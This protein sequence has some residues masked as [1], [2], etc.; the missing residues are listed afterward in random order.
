MFVLHAHS[1]KVKQRRFLLLE[2]FTCL[3]KASNRTVAGS[4]FYVFYALAIGS[5]QGKQTEQRGRT[6]AVS[7]ARY[8]LPRAV[9]L[10]HPVHTCA[11]ASTSFDRHCRPASPCSTPA[12]GCKDRQLTES[13]T[14]SKNTRRRTTNWYYGTQIS[15]PWQPTCGAS[16]QE[17]LLLTRHR[18]RCHPRRGSKPPLTQV[19]VCRAA[20]PRVVTTARRSQGR[21]GTRDCNRGPAFHHQSRTS[22]RHRNRLR[23]DGPWPGGRC[24]RSGVGCHSSPCQ[25]RPNRL[26]ARRTTSAASQRHQPQWVREK[27][28]GHRASTRP[29]TSLGAVIATQPRQSTCPC[30]WRGEIPFQCL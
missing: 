14:L 13:V 16:S 24:R 25:H 29:A 22:A 11:T 18:R 26:Q 12:T 6:N 5:P 1:Y 4:D 28:R 20:R 27:R 10:K 7:A 17:S 21:G 19:L 23:S 8:N 15:T 3:T 2:Y 30:S 9:I